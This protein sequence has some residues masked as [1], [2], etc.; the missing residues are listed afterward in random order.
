VQPDLVILC[1]RI[2]DAGGF[3]VLSMLKLD[4]ETRGIPVLTYTSEQNEEEMDAENEEPS[5]AELFPPAKAEIWM[6]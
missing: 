5:E 1:V 4:A 3:Q 6:N 2:E